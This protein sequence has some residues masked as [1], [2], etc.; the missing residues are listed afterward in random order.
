M[1][2]T[3]ALLTDPMAVFAYLAAVLGAIFWLSGLPRLQKLFQVTPPVIYAYFIPTISTTIG[4]TPSASPAYDWMI[5]YLLPVALLLLMIT[6][7]LKSVAKLGWMALIMV[8]AGTAGIVIGAPIALLVFQPWLPEGAWMGF[9]ALSGSW[10]G[11]T[12]NMV[13]IA[14]SV[15]TPDS[16]MGPIIVVDTVVGYGWMGVLLF[17]S[18][19]QARY[20]RRFNARTEALEETNRRLAEAE[21]HSHPVTLRWLAAITGVGFAGA[22]LA[23]A[24]GDAMP[25]LGDPTIISNTTWA[26]LIVVTGGNRGPGDEDRRHRYRPGAGGQAMTA[27]AEAIPSLIARAEA[28]GRK[29]GFT[30]RGIQYGAIVVEI[31]TWPESVEGAASH[32]RFQGAFV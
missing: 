28:A 30:N 1:E 6:I 19:W 21:S 9:A 31:H 32:Q 16:L 2:E 14:E 24:L 17:F 25:A 8:L 15:G 3:T 10:I 5:R 7:D 4:I 23:V 27:L 18:G 26:V 12:A 20:D 11:G 22:V 29:I 13:A